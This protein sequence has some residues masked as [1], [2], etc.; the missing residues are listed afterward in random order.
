MLIDEENT[1]LTYMV[2]VVDIIQIG[3]KKLKIREKKPTPNKVV[4]VIDLVRRVAC[5]SPELKENDEYLFMGLDRGGS[6][7]LDET[8]FVKLWP[9][10]P[11]NS[12]KKQLDKFARQHICKP[13]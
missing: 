9:T 12:D 2:E 3:D 11:G 8:S 6:Y 13:K 7:Y 5:K 4:K 1:I 10:D